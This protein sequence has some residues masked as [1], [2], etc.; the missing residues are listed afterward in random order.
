MTAEILTAIGGLAGVLIGGVEM[1]LSI[2]RLHSKVDRLEERMG[3]V[4]RRVDSPPVHLTAVT[5]DAE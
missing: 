1:R 5:D 4:E 3:T 2:S